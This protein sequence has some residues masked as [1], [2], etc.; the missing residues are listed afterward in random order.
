MLSRAER[1]ALA[2]IEERLAYEDPDLDA[3][4]AAPRG[5]AAGAADGDMWMVGVPCWPCPY[6]LPP[7]VSAKLP[8]PVLVAVTAGLLALVLVIGLLAGGMETAPPEV[9]CPAGEAGCG[10]GA[11]SSPPAA[12]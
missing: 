8:W 1:K 12:G 3:L 10:G 6:V 2:E 5:E 7:G 4:L 11:P 9:F